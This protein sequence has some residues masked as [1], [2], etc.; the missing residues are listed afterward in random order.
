[1]IPN[2]NFN[3]TNKIDLIINYQLIT[4]PLILWVAVHCIPA[5]FFLEPEQTHPIHQ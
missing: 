3:S 1:M 2:H 4:T 5:S